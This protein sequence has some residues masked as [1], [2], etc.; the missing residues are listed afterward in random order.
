MF[1]LSLQENEASSDID[2]MCRGLKTCPV[3]SLVWRLSVIL[4]QAMVSLGGVKTV[5][6]IWHEFV[7]EM[8]YRWE[9]CISIPG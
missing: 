5:A 4:A 2:N 7:Q 3:D 9:K 8:R 1:F 6:Y